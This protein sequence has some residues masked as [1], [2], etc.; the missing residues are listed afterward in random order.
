MLADGK[1]NECHV[2]GMT[3]RTILEVLHIGSSRLVRCKVN[4]TKGKPGGLNGSQQ[5]PWDLE[6][7]NGFMQGLNYEES[8]PCSHRR[9]KRYIV[10]QV[11]KRE[12]ING[13]EVYEKMDVI[14][15]KQLYS[16]YVMYYNLKMK[17]RVAETTSASSQLT[18]VSSP[19]NGDAMSQMTRETNLATSV[20]ST[21]LSRN[22]PVD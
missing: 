11:E 4:I 19:L 21:I 10:E 2:R 1:I 20:T 8:F 14:T 16:K 15:W 9:M 3:D 12:E 6:T 7:S 22:K 13:R 18:Q 5:T 17:R